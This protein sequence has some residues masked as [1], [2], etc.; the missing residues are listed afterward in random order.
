MGAPNLSTQP[1]L[2]RFF[3]VRIQSVMPDIPIQFDLFLMVNGKPT[4]F[5]R[6]GQTITAERMES[7]MKHGGQRFMILEEHRPL[8]MAALKMV[9]NDPSATAET[10]SKYIKESA[11]LHVHDLFEKP[12]VADTVQNAEMMVKEMVDLVSEDV[13]AVAHLMK[14]SVHDYY[15]YN[16][17]VDVSVYTIALAK[18]VLGADKET[19]I[20]AGLA[21]LLHDIG[22]RK[23]DNQIINKKSALSQ[24][25]WEE[26][27]RHPTYG[28][29]LLLNVDNVPEEAKRAVYEHHENY[30]G[31]GYPEKKK[32]DEVC[33]LSHLVAIADV[34]DALTTER[35][36][37]KAMSAKE[38][39]DTM[40][41]MQPGKFD[42][43]IFAAFNKN[44]EKKAKVRLEPEFDP[45]QESSLNKIKKN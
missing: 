32:G 13:G 43:D 17:C 44:F 28:K 3:E 20:Q 16:H 29:E 8:Y 39:L 5:R 1:S 12:S 19:L 9:L 34:F 18:H 37:H 15:T 21:G 14:L 11:F 24:E 6:Q 42:P 40:F 38:A 27:K 30:D 41:G 33:K 25:E 10:K 26:V 7:L 2:T 4:L 22:K 45:C 35:S 23:I 36:Y 31:T